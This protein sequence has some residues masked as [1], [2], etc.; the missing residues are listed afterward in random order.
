VR[1]YSRRGYDW[2]KRLA[3]LAEALQGMPTHCAIPDAELCLPVD[4]FPNFC[5]L[6]ADAPSAARGRVYAFDLLGGS[7]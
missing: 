4:G 1:L 5:G 7:S 3:A 6:V 2:G